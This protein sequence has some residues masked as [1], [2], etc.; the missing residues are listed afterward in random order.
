MNHH[1]RDI[2]DKLGPPLWWDEHAVPRY[3]PFSPD[4]CANIYADEVVLLEIAC[5]SC[6]AIFRVAMS[7]S[8][9]QRI[10]EAAKYENELFAKEVE[11]Q[12]L[13][14]DISE[15]L[16]HY[17]DPPNNHCCPAGPTMNCI[18]RRVLE[19]WK[20]EKQEWVRDSSYEVEI[21]EE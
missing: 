20:R 17:G 10:C 4:E 15:K 8:R 21:E 3:C 11:E 2:I 19:Y 1:Y 18:D 9:F 7:S 13:C 6:G 5:Q 16:L 12:K 14:D